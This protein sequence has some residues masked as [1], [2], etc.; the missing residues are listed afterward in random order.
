MPICDVSG[1]TVPRRAG[2]LSISYCERNSLAWTVHR[3]SAR[4]NGVTL[5][6][7]LDI[8]YVQTMLIRLLDNA[9]KFC[10]CRDHGHSRL[11]NFAS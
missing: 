1:I 5:P 4:L 2:V 9:I 11:P 3:L 8:L 10:H 6:P 7:F